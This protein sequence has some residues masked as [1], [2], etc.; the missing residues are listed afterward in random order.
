MASA[1][2]YVAN[3]IPGTNMPT[4]SVQSFRNQKVGGLLTGTS[5]GLV[6]GAQSVA[7]P[8]ASP[9]PSE[10]SVGFSRQA[11]AVQ[12]NSVQLMEYAKISGQK[13][14]AAIDAKSAQDRAAALS[15][16]SR[17]RGA[18]GTNVKYRPMAAR[19]QAGPQAPI[20][21]GPTVSR[22]QSMLG[23]FPGLR[24]TEI[25]GNR[26]SDVR[27]GVARVPTSYHYDTKNPAV[28]IGGSTAQLDSLYREMV[29]QGGWRQI[30]WRTKGH[31][32]HIHVA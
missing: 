29:R 11:G 18:G 17:Q 2:D 19:P 20:T 30:L 22:I 14:Q 8:Q 24:I 10:A 32:D 23:R 26:A 31:Y 25:G 3:K 7:E 1:F 9:A 16:A 5:P 15:N 13:R 21:K 6:G 12:R 28:D 27:R 4:Q